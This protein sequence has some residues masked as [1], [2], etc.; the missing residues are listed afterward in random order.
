MNTWFYREEPKNGDSGRYVISKRIFFLLLVILIVLLAG[1]LVWIMLTRPVST[2]VTEVKSKVAAENQDPQKPL[3]IKN[4][5]FST[6][7]DADLKL[8]TDNSRPA[9]RPVLRQLIFLSKTGEQLSITIGVLPGEGIRAIGDYNYRIKNPAI[10]RKVAIDDLDTNNEAFYYND[11]NQKEVSIF[12]ENKD[13]YAGI[14]V[15]GPV[16]NFNKLES[17]IGPL[18]EN[19]YW[20]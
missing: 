6:K 7:I 10:Y 18:I 4:E 3:V 17:I 19:W 8:K 5:Y 15:S 20:L 1:F 16:S 9:D 11:N 2:K 14:S 12:I 13:Y